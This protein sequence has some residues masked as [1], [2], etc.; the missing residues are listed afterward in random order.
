MGPVELHFPFDID[1][2]MKTRRGPVM[3]AEANIFS[4]PSVRFT[5]Q[6]CNEFRCDPSWA[7]SAKDPHGSPTFV[8]PN[9]FQVI[10]AYF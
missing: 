4:A 8:D 6:F 5:N 3:K 1:H 10:Q 2:G 7:F 9:L